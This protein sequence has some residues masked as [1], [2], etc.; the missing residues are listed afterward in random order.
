MDAQQI[1]ELYWARA[2]HAITET[3]QKYGRYCHSI[4]FNILHNDEDSE[5]CVNDTYLNAWNSIPPHRPAVLKAFLGKLTR[6]LALNRYKQCTAEKRGNGQIP[7]ILDELHE[8][9]PAAENTERI[10]DDMVLTDVLNR[11]LASLPVEQRRIFMRR[12]WYM[13]SV[14]EIAA[15]YGLSE[16]K[17][18]MSLLRARNELKRRLEKE[19]ITI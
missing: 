10:L 9:L 2:E 11:F 3:T 14:K 17:V 6:N 12:Y 16:S 13:R 1:V 18:K 5:E 8:C 4:A 19:G 7:L 15:D